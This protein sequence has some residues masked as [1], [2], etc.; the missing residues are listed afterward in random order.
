M[1]IDKLEQPA[2][3][4]D[5]IYINYNHHEILKEIPISH[6]IMDDPTDE[7]MDRIQ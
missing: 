1:I 7:F 3:S 5:Q 6:A 4:Y 2:L